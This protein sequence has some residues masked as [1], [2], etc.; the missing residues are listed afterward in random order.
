[1]KNK[2]I[3]TWFLAF[4]VLL[5]WGIIIYK[6]VM[7]SSEKVPMPQ[8]KPAK[9]GKRAVKEFDYQLLTDYPDPFFPGRKHQTEN[10][11]SN[12]NPRKE[13]SV[14]WPGLKYFGCISNAEQIRAMV[15]LDGKSVILKPQGVLKGQFVLKQITNDSILIASKNEKKWYRK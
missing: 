9:E 6:I 8:V 13:A 7:R 14:I 1:M 4:A 2:K 5:V 10:K 11:G 15:S 12:S 3:T